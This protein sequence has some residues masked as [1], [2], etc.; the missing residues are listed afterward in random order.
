MVND[1]EAE[2][3][4]RN[5]ARKKTAKAEAERAARSLDNVHV[6]VARRVEPKKKFKH[7]P[8]INASI[9]PRGAVPSLADFMKDKGRQAPDNFLDNMI[10]NFGNSSMPMNEIAEFTN[11][12]VSE[13]EQRYK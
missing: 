8:T 7:E 6:K 3:K 9:L 10:L 2:K 4:A 13:V 5:K 12:T 11:L 1:R